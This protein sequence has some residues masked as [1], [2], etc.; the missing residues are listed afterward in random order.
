M[1]RWTDLNL[2]PGEEVSIDSLH[3]GVARLVI[4]PKGDRVETVPVEDLPPDFRVAG[5]AF[6]VRDTAPVG[7]APTTDRSLRLV[8]AESPAQADT[9]PHPDGAA[10]AGADTKGGDTLSATLAAETDALMDD[11]FSGPPPP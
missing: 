11:V 6:R 7:E 5:V 9:A 4:G 1:K 2:S 10:A 8:S 3:D